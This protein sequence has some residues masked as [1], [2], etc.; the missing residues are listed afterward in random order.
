[1]LF[2]FFQWCEATAFGTMIRESPW[3]FAVIESVHL[4]ALSVIGGAV[5]LVDLRLL[6]WGLQKSS[7]R[8]L[9][10]NAQP[11]LN[12][13]LIVMLV[14]GLGLFFSEPTKCY[15]STPFWVKMWSLLFAMI[16]TYTIRRRVLSRDDASIA[17]I[18]GKLTA[19]VSLA[20]WFGVGAGGRWIGFSGCV[21]TAPDAHSGRVGG[22][23]PPIQRPPVALR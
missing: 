16:Y 9:A 18:M 2:P 19:L 10:R 7:I 15:Y 8:E 11:W 12:A 21:S 6:G 20:L 22:S 17:P 14:T 4:L 13:S 3:A 5:L 1:M 23:Y